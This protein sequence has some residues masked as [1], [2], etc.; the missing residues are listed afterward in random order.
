MALGSTQ[1]VYQEHFL[2][3]KLT[4]LPPSCAIVMKCGN[5]NFLEP[6][7][8]LQVCNGTDLPVTFFLRVGIDGRLIEARLFTSYFRHTSFGL[9]S[10]KGGY[11]W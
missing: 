5:P 4:I 9:K 3:A 1:P 2:V 7:G 11:F 8:P 6:S 10:A